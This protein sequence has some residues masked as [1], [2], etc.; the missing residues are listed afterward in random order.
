MSLGGKAKRRTRDPQAPLKRELEEYPEPLQD[1]L[2]SEASIST[3]VSSYELGDFMEHNIGRKSPAATFGSYGIGSVIL[4]L[5][6]QNSINLII[7][8]AHIS[9][10]TSRCKLNLDFRE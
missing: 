7:S 5:E 4:P 8:G 6:L 9:T 1:T 10:T 2:S 3:T